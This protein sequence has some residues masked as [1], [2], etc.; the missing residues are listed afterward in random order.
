MPGYK[1]KS[2]KSVGRPRK[3]TAHASTQTAVAKFSRKIAGQMKP[4]KPLSR[5][6]MPNTLTL[7]LKY[8]DNIQSSVAGGVHSQMYRLNSLF[9][10]DKTNV[11]HQAYFRD[12]IIALYNEYQI[13]K[14]EL[15]STV[16]IYT[17]DANVRTPLALC[18]G[19]EK[20]MATGTNMQLQVERPYN[21][22]RTAHVGKSTV[23]KKTYYNN[24]ILGE[25]WSDYFLNADFQTIVGSNPNNE[26]N[27]QILLEPVDQVS[28][29]A[30]TM[31][32]EL[33]FTVVLTDLVLP[34]QS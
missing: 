30:F 25:K 32:N 11:G 18:Y 16:D 20:D 1:K 28:T 2:K 34:S 19:T 3:G 23:F 29:V 8:A 12:Q 24:K 15:I 33:W 10:P 22:R 31:R 7:R 17:A 26:A 4:H 21:Y 6:G 13:Y 27:L 14:A 9:D 5:H